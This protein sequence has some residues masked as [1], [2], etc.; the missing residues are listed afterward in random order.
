M[1]IN[2]FN[3][4]KNYDSIEKQVYFLA[5]HSNEI[6]EFNDY[7]RYTFARV[8]DLDDED[9]TESFD[10]LKYL[11]NQI[12]GSFVEYQTELEQ[13]NF[14]DLNIFFTLLSE[15]D[16][17]EETIDILKK[18]SNLIINFRE[19]SIK[20]TLERRLKELYSSNNG[21]NA[22]IAYRFP[23]E[24][25][26]KYTI[27][28]ANEYIRNLKYYDNV[29]FIGSPNYYYNMNSIFKA[30]NTYF[31]SYDIYRNELKKRT[32]IPNNYIENSGIF[33]GIS[34]N[35]SSINTHSKL[36]ESNDAIQSES[37][38]H[39]NKF[40]N[41][42]KK[43]SQ[44]HRSIQVLTARAL[45]LANE[46]CIFLPINS[47]VRVLDKKTKKINIRKITDILNDDW[48]I[49]KQS[50]DEEYIHQ[51]AKEIVGS[52]YGDM[53]ERITKYKI[54]LLNYMDENGID[55]IGLKDVFANFGIKVRRQV[56]QDWVYGS[57]IAPR[58]YKEILGFLNYNQKA[59]VQLES[60]YKSIRRAHSLAGRILLRNLQK[61]VDT[62]DMSDIETAMYRYNTFDM[63]IEN[64]GEFCIKKVKVINKEPVEVEYSEL[65]RVLKIS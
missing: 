33:T 14:D 36:D 25:E 42:L 38:Y 62:F 15:K 10:V 65:Y 47:K 22:V 19:G 48:V 64:I 26:N 31:L 57:T 28:T 44:N 24:I 1:Y 60:E 18:F 63:D 27:V 51:K 41:N 7:Y 61:I 35:K 56:L 29:F 23:Q 53:F 5:L 58:E 54:E 55:L 43:E 39:F 20:N 30:T 52:G 34:F 46:E 8:R 13:F 16:Y 11:F 3:M 4:L 37:S 17:K 6:T 12:R 45:E 2:E 49:I 21:N 50:S 9:L 32:I 40:I 59:I